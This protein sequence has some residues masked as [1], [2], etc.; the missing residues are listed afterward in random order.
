MYERCFELCFFKDRTLS[1]LIGEQVHCPDVA[2]KKLPPF[3]NLFLWI[4]HLFMG[5]HIIDPA[6]ALRK[7]MWDY[8][9]F[10]TGE[11]RKEQKRK[12]TRTVDTFM[13][14]YF[15]RWQK[16]HPST[17]ESEPAPKKS[18][19]SFSE[20]KALASTSDFQPSVAL[21]PLEALSS[22]AAAPRQARRTIMGP[23]NPGPSTSTS[24]PSNPDPTPGPSNPTPDPSN[25]Y[26]PT[27]STSRAVEEIDLSVPSPSPPPP[28]PTLDWGDD[29]PVYR[30]TTPA[31]VAPPP[32][33]VPPPALLDASIDRVARGASTPPIPSPAIASPP[34]NNILEE[35]YQEAIRDDSPGVQALANLYNEAAAA[36]PSTFPPLLPAILASGATPTL[37]SAVPSTSAPIAPDVLAA[38]RSRPLP[39]PTFTPPAVPSTSAPGPSSSAEGGI[40][41]SSLKPLVLDGNLKRILSVHRVPCPEFI[42]DGD[43]H[44]LL[45]KEAETAEELLVKIGRSWGMRYHVNDENMVLLRTTI[46]TFARQRRDKCISWL[47]ANR[48]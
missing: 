8:L 29:V 34:T 14:R 19:S 47:E 16:K 40:Y 33:V 39:N 22:L 30:P 23:I 27:P 48:E 38:I 12:Q 17:E 46:E 21:S 31:A 26:A 43:E 37:P 44:D 1:T 45:L 20:L 3:R 2:C 6:A 36:P 11:D 13:N 42:L 35:A 4:W 9:D 5:I 15:H 25:P 7:D 41:Q 28:D 32:A 24:G 18:K 10:A